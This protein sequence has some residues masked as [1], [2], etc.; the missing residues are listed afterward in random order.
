[1]RDFGAQILKMARKSCKAARKSKQL[2]CNHNGPPLFSKNYS[3]KFSKQVK[4]S[5]DQESKRTILNK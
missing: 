5:P 4:M 3:R 1:M 2:D